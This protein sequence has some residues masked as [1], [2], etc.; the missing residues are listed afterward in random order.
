MSTYKT[1]RVDNFADFYID[2]TFLKINT[3]SHSHKDKDCY[4]INVYEVS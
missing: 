2:V 3:G 4:S 1:V